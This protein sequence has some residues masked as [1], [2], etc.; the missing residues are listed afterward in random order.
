[1]GRQAIQWGLHLLEKNKAASQQGDESRLD[2]MEEGSLSS[3]SQVPRF[4]ICLIDLGQW[5]LGSQISE[6]EIE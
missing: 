4:A 6:L 2:L 1:M 5:L 3:S